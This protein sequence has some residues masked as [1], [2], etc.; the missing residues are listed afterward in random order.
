[1]L[2]DERFSGNC[3]CLLVYFVE[4][5]RGSKPVDEPIRLGRILLKTSRQLL[6]AQGIFFRLSH[7]NP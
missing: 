2:P 5:T 7:S 6:L 3:R 1:L 4:K